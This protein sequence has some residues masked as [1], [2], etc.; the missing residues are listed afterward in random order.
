M[1]LFGKMFSKKDTELKQELSKAQAIQAVG[2]VN[3]N[4][5]IMSVLSAVMIAMTGC[6]LNKQ[7][8][9]EGNQ[10]AG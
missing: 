3:L 5:R 8:I 4:K 2:R 10:Y 6:S 1:G 7:I 9:M